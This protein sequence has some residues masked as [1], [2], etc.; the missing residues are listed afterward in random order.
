MPLAAVEAP[1]DAVRLTSKRFEN[2]RSVK[3]K[4]LIS[5]SPFQL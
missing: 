2:W 3:V 4:A 5:I 1:E